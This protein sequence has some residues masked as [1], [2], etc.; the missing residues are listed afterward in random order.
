MYISR[1]DSDRNRIRGAKPS[2]TTATVGMKAKIQNPSP[3]PSLIIQVRRGR[4][5][6]I[7]YSKLGILV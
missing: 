5:S 2:E 6:I 4:T 7:G 1:I 3:S